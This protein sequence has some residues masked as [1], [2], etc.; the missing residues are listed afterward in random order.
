MYL[1]VLNTKTCSWIKHPRP[2]IVAVDRTSNLLDA[3]STQDNNPV[4]QSHAPADAVARVVARP[5]PPS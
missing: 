5:I 1:Q 2:G 4:G 3:A